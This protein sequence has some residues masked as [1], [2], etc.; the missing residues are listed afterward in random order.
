M[1]ERT[2][3][4]R[5]RWTRQADGYDRGARAQRLLLGGLR[6]R[7][8]GPARGRILE[9]AV[10]TGQNLEYYADG[11][12]VTGVD[13][14]PAMLDRAR[15]RAAALGLRT[16]LVEG[17]AQH[18][19]FGDGEFDTVVCGLALCTI[20]DQ[21]RALDEMRRVLMPGG[22]LRLADH[23]EYTRWPLRGRE[24]RKE[25]PRRRPVEVAAE[26]GFTVD[27]VRRS[28]FGLLDEVTAHRP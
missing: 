16:R 11:A 8:C 13:L 14:T 26:A 15:E 21:R 20:P 4:M 2:Q 19:P 9:V 5:E 24:A 18:L 27:R 12:D 1:D 17:D 7:L 28:A 22:S 25:R 10:G 23:V 3:A 6:K